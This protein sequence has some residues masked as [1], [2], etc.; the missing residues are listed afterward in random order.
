MDADCR[1]AADRIC[2]LRDA[3]RAPQHDEGWWAARRD[4]GEVVRR[5]VATLV[6]RPTLVIL[7]RPKA[8]SKDAAGLNLT[9]TPAAY[10]SR[11]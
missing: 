7:R 6:Q 9:L 1:R 2:V 11:R 8:V 4:E 3:L 5:R 10:A